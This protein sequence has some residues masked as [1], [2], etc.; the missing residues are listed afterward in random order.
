MDMTRTIWILTGLV[1]AVML[2]PGCTVKDQDATALSGPS[3]LATSITLSATP[4]SLR[5]DG[6]SQS[7]IVLLAQNASSQPVASL[8]V[9][10]EIS[11]G[12]VIVDFGAL[13]AKNLTTGTDGKCSV[14]YTAPEAS[15]DTSDT[16]TTI[17]ILATP[18][19]TDY[20]NATTRAVSIA[21]VPAGIITPPN[22]TPVPSFL[23][24]PTAPATQADVTFDASTSTD[25]DGTIVSYDWLFGDGS[26][27]SGRVTTHQFTSAGTFTVTLTVT[28][29]DGY[30]A[31]TSK[32]VTVT[33]S[34]NP[35]AA[36]T[37]SPTN[38]K[39]HESILF[40]ASTSTAATGR[41]IVSYYWDFGTDRTGYG[42]T[43][44]KTYD[45]VATYVVTL[46]VTDDIG[47]TGVT[48]KNVT[49]VS[50]GLAAA[51]VVSPTDPAPG[52]SVN[53]DASTSTAG[54]G[55]TITNYKWNF[56]DGS[57]IVNG[58]ATAYKVTNHT[59]AVAGT[60][61]VSLTI[62]DDLGQTVTKTVEVT[63]T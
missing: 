4:S 19:G 10:M 13:S 36:F 51:F 2:L 47:K 45:E 16:G 3:T 43:Y 56:G 6:S 29:D 42:V 5:R 55:R 52:T 28:D 53:F 8:P 54:A 62:T 50:S 23:F 63:V 22:D 27:G 1:L 33:T 40:N 30:A 11:V 32:T 14:V 58:D 20:A 18:T 44:T 37:F 7:T 49:V 9:R 21:L 57:A 24:S 61:V 26:A 38:P 35:T 46:T 48:T 59:F 60:Y 34:A 39:Q 31:S 15:S 41:S 25:S 12:G 17:Q